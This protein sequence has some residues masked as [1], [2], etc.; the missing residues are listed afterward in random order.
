MI[1]VWHINYNACIWDRDID[2]SFVYLSADFKRDLTR[3]FDL[4]FNIMTQSEAFFHKL[5]PIKHCP[6]WKYGWI[7]M[8]SVANRVGYVS[9]PLWNEQLAFIC[10]N[11]MAQMPCYF[12]PV[13][14]TNF[15]VFFS[16]LCNKTVFSLNIER[17]IVCFSW[18]FN[19]HGIQFSNGSTSNDTDYNA[20]HTNS[21][22]IH[23]Y[24]REIR[25]NFFFFLHSISLLLWWLCVFFRILI[26]PRFSYGIQMK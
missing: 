8:N 25:A 24:C 22:C 12:F 6:K 1:F 19:M 5:F 9:H 17:E 18:L 11:A 15:V 16:W 20:T 26:L 4:K 21:L 14:F 23:W 10:M 2:S 7:K 13:F 3:L